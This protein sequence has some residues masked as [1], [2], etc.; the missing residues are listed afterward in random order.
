[1]FKID[2][3]KAGIILSILFLFLSTLLIPK[4]VQAD[5]WSNAYDHLIPAPNPSVTYEIVEKNGK[6]FKQYSIKGIRLDDDPK[7]FNTPYG[8]ESIYDI[9]T[10][11]PNAVGTYIQE[12]YSKKISGDP[13][14]K[15][16]TGWALD[17]K[18]YMGNA[19]S[20]SVAEGTTNGYINEWY[21]LDEVKNGLA[22]MEHLFDAD[23]KAKL[24]SMN[25]SEKVLKTTSDS[26]DARIRKWQLPVGGLYSPESGKTNPQTGNM[27]ILYY[28]NEVFLDVTLQVDIECKEDCGPP[29]TP[30]PTTGGV[31]TIDFSASNASSM[32][33]SYLQASPNGSI[34]SSTGE[35]DAV[36]GIPTSENLTVEASTEEYLFDQQFQQKTG[37]VTYSGINAKK[38][39]TLKWTEEKITGTGKDQKKEN[40]PKSEKVTVETTVNGIQRNFSY[41]ES[42]R[43]DVWKAA[44]ADFTN[45]ALPNGSQNVPVSLSVTANARHSSVIENHVFPKPCPEI[46]LPA[47]TVDGGKT[48]P[49]PPDISGEAKGAA[50]AAI[51]Q[52]DV[53]NDSVTFKGSTLMSDAMTTSNGPTPSNT[54]MPSRVTAKRS[55]LTIDRT[56]TNYLRAPSTGRFNYSLVFS[57][58][59]ASNKSF[60]FG[61]NDVT[62][63]T[64]TVIYASTSDDKEHDQRIN[65]PLRST[66]VNSDT[67]IAALILDRQFTVKM[68]T[69]GQHRNIPGYGKRDYQKWIKEK[70]VKFP[71]DVYSETKQSYYPSNTWI[72]VPVDMQEAKFFMPVWVTEGRYKV[73]FKAIAEN[74]PASNGMEEKEA[75]KT[76]PNGNVEGHPS[77]AHTATDSLTVDVVG[78][79]YD[80]QITDVTDHNW[81]YMF[82]QMDNL[83]PTG[84]KF[85]VGLK[86][87]DGANR[88]NVEPFTL[89]LSHASNTNGLINN[90][91]KLGYTFKFDVKTK[92]DMQSNTDAI[93]IKPTFFFVSNDGRNRQEVDLYYNDNRNIFVKVGSTEDN[94]YREVA[95]NETSR[96]VPNNELTNNAYQYFDNAER[97]GLKEIAQ[98]YFR[99]GFATHYMRK[100]SKEAVQTGPYAWQLLNWKLR[101]FRGPN[102]NVVGAS[103]TMVPKPDLVTK[104]QTWY[105]EYSL[106]S[107]TYAIPKGS[108]LATVGAVDDTHSIFLK[109]GYIVVNFDVQ[110]INEGD[111]ANLYLSYTK[112]KYMSQWRMEGGKT[113]FTDGYG[114][115]FA[116]N[117]GDMIYYHANQSVE[118]DF[119]SSVTH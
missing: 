3:R 85:N 93:R 112:A 30:P 8:K 14:I 11:N 103:A 28:D 32:N 16:H 111:T 56:K 44:S 97:Y 67:E 114:Y 49:S 60:N 50:E 64:P 95:L 17:Y 41:W 63:H 15:Q 34:Y 74:A 22:E 88:G 104:E 83:T 99:T 33:R 79:L 59:G 29:P 42:P 19:W 61:V 4:V 55:N 13:S 72:K 10:R 100:M 46:V 65:P 5:E 57:L 47:T 96:F 45:Y 40:I 27:F 66:P 80:L 89:P 51:G 110:T 119:S 18:K 2:F 70:M 76:I 92:G 24:A 35:F 31:C 81:Q 7:I 53:K 108:N 98:D 86:N 94:I 77:A 36:Q 109:N 37:K 1:M 43:Y 69:I 58:G 82:R 107:K 6:K 113:Q 38:E 105:G 78:R 23:L 117:E 68:P 73:E 26:R 116:V 84:N 62:V 9:Y 48:K 12:L 101:T 118:L 71:F 90:A 25:K 106:P 21:S 54:P 102:E 20:D 39:V 115:D 75:N 91:V 52:P 87:I